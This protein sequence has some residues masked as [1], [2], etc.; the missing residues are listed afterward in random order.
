MEELREQGVKV[1]RHLSE[2]LSG[3][4][5]SFKELDQYYHRRNNCLDY[6]HYFFY[7]SCVDKTSIV[8][9]DINSTIDTGLLW[10]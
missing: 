4:P 8:Q 10:T 3:L 9:K 2:K 5:Q 6:L 1:Q 7:P